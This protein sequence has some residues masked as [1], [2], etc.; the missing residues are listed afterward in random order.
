[1]SDSDEMRDA[2]DRGRAEV[3]RRPTIAAKLEG[4]IGETM[5]GGRLKTP[6]H[7][8]IKWLAEAALVD[9]GRA[10]RCDGCNLWSVIDGK[11]G[12]CGLRELGVGM[13]P[14]MYDGIVTEADFGCVRFTPASVGKQKA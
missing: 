10:A 11:T 7:S 3:E 8:V 13:W 9:A 14:E 1:M 5:I 2:L 12:F 6:D 4:I